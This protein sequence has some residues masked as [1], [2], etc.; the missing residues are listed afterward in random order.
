MALGS[1]RHHHVDRARLERRQA[2][3]VLADGLVGHTVEIGQALAPVVRIGLGGHVVV[4]LPRDQRERARADGLRRALR[5]AVELGQRHDVADL[6]GEVLGESHQGLRDGDGHGEVAHLGDVGH[7]CE[8]LTRQGGLAQRIDVGQE[9]V[10][11]QV[12][13]VVEHHS[14]SQRDRP[15]RQVGV[16]RHRLGQVRAGRA[17]GADGGQRVVDR[18]GVGQSRVVE[19]VR[20]RQEAVDLG[21][22]ADRDAPTPPG[23][24]VADAGD[25]HGRCGGGRASRQKRGPD[26]R[27]PGGGRHG[28]AAAQECPPA[29]SI[30]GI[31][32]RSPSPWLS[33]WCDV[34]S[35]RATVGAPW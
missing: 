17:V 14:R 10:R 29:V 3:L 8:R 12:G 7:R 9:Y 18:V 1:R 25:G 31:N 6:G 26:A 21:V 13:P 33:P 5:G 34:Q 27:Q 28:C 32:H 2:R 15:H 30:R 16:G 23:L 11:V 4:G 19:V 20:R 24:A 22:E 35:P